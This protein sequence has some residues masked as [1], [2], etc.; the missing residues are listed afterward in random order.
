MMGAL[1][2]RL[3]TLRV[4]SLQLLLPAEDG[5]P[6]LVLGNGHAALHADTYALSV[7]WRIR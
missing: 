3:R 5:A 4:G 2:E 7:R 6:F 1:Y